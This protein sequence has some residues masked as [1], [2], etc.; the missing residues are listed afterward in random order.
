MSVYSRFTIK[1]TT[2]NIHGSD[3]IE[4]LLLLSAGRQ[5]LHRGDRA[6]V[7]GFDIRIFDALY[8]TCRDHIFPLREEGVVRRVFILVSDGDDNYSRS[9]NSDAIKMCQRA[10]TIVYAIGTNVSP[11]RSRGDEVLR[12]I[13]DATGGLAF[14]P[15]RIENV[16]TG[17]RKIEE[18]LRS[19]YSL[20]YRPAAFKNDGS[21]RAINLQA[22]DRRYKV[23]VH[24]GYFA[25]L[26]SE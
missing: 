24:T 14:Y 12:V 19:Q 6:F 5:I 23:R 10:E 11:S 22:F 7:E 20:I 25:P 2:E 18:E 1:G 13:S 4:L 26:P 15:V 17:F 16:V 3:L 9:Q 21:F 8:K